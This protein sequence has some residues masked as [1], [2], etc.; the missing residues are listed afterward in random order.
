MTM[1]YHEYSCNGIN[2]SFLKAYSEYAVSQ[3]EAD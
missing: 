1:N 2:I 3:M